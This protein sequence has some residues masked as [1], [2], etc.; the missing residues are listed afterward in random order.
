MTRMAI[1]KF[2]ALHADAKNTGWQRTNYY[3]E[4]NQETLLKEE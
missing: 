2:C 4:I 1:A 3:L